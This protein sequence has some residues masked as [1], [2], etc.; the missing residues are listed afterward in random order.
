MC[1]MKIS[2]IVKKKV[3]DT[4]SLSKGAYLVTVEN[5]DLRTTEKLIIE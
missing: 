4:R 1:F 2:Q 5:G 3:I